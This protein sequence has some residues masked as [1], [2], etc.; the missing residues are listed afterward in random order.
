M[1]SIVEFIFNEKIIEKISLW[2]PWT[3]ANQNAY[4]IS[5]ILKIFANKL[6]KKNVDITFIKN[7]IK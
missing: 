4:L 5:S 1:N 6:F 7:K 2:I 3:N